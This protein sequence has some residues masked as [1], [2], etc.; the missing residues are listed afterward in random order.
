MRIVRATDSHTELLITAGA[1]AWFLTSGWMQWYEAL[2]ISQAIEQQHMPP[3]WIVTITLS[4]AVALAGMA[5]MIAGFA[6]A[7]FLR[8]ALPD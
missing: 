6:L 3:D 5:A 1:T 2:W 8:R 7:G 4:N